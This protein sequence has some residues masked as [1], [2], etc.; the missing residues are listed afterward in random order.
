MA[1]AS[2]FNQPALNGKI[3]I[4]HAKT[5]NQVNKE[6]NMIARP[7]LI[8][9]DYFLTIIQTTRNSGLLA[10][11]EFIQDIERQEDFDVFDLTYVG[12]KTVAEGYDTETIQKVFNNY[13]KHTSD[14][15]CFDIITQSCLSIQRGDNCNLLILYY[16]SL[17]PTELRKS[18]Q[19][20]SIAKKYGYDFNYE[21]WVECK[22]RIS[23][24]QL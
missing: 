16:A 23:Q 9:M 5:I 3:D 20:L 17:L 4:Y 22:D 2:P 6:I 7:P 13:H 21:T 10:L 15:L 24:R 8:L 1:P 14:E 18:E 19:F 12:L 11:E